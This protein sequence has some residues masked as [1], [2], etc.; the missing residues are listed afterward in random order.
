MPGGSPN[1]RDLIMDGVRVAQTY[2]S[3]TNTSIPTRGLNLSNAAFAGW[4]EPEDNE[5]DAARTAISQSVSVSIPI[6]IPNGMS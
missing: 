3:T 5:R 4:S 1:D 6:P 2:F